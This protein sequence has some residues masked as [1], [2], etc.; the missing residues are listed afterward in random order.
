MCC[1]PAV[2]NL[3]GSSRANKR[4]DKHPGRGTWEDLWDGKR[5]IIIMFFK[6]KQ[7]FMGN[8]KTGIYNLSL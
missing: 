3:L 6:E 7:Y 5:G 2:T 1:E 8:F 4:A